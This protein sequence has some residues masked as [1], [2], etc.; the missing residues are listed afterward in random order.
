MTIKTFYDMA[1]KKEQLS[2]KITNPEIIQMI[3]GIAEEEHRTNH[4]TV[5]HILKLH[6]E[7]MRMVG[8]S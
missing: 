8:T 2:I 7:A 1:T 5:I 6:F 3:E 4:N